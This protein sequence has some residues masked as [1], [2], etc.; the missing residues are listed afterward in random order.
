MWLKAGEAAAIKGVKDIA[1]RLVA[2][3]ELVGNL[4][5]MVP[6][7]AGQQNLATAHSKTV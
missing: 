1:D 4:A 6:T 5:G 3:T 7:L 2:T